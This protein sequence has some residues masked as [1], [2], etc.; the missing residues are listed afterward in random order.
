MIKNTVITRGIPKAAVLAALYNNACSGILG[1][2]WNFLDPEGQEEMSADE[3]D[4]L[5]HST[6]GLYFDYIGVKCLKVDLSD[7]YEFDS[8]LYDRENGSFSA[9]SAIAPLRRMYAACA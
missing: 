7:D 2:L 8:R 5:I 1:K 6:P 3:A 9:E 4:E